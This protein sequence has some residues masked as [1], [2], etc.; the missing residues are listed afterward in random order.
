MLAI[1]APM[2]VCALAS[3]YHF[4]V[5]TVVQYANK[6]HTGRNFCGTLIRKRSVLGGCMRPSK[7]ESIGEWG[8]GVDRCFAAIARSQDYLALIKSTVQQWARAGTRNLVE[9]IVYYFEFATIVWYI[10]IKYYFAAFFFKIPLSLHCR[11]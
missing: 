3:N 8:P 4:K 7:S 2:H 10:Y 1:E 11:I 5:R 9:F 6:A